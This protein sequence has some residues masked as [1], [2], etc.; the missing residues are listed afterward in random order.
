MTRRTLPILLDVDRSSHDRVELQPL[1]FLFLLHGV[2]QLL[3]LVLAHL[4]GPLGLRLGS[5][6]L[7]LFGILLVRVLLLVLLLVLLALLLLG[8]L[9][10]L[11][12]LVLV[13]LLILLVLVLIILLLLLF[14][15]QFLEAQQ[16][17]IVG[18]YG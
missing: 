1:G 16:F 17:S 12:L 15:D 10:I 11:L 13:L 7:L 5:F 18:K 2:E 6:I 8:V 4:L 3:G 14:F 9:L